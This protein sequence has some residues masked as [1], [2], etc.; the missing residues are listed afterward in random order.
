MLVLLKSKPSSDYNMII[1]RTPFRISFLGGGTDYPVWYENNGGGAVLSVTIDKYCYVICRYLPPFFDFNYRIRY[2]SHE[3][4]KTVDEIRH[5]S[6]RECLRFLEVTQG[7][8]MQHNADL[9]AMSGLGSSSAFTV[10][11]LNALYALR[12]K[13]EVFKRN[14]ALGAIHV[15][16]ERIKE[17][18]GSQDQTAAAYGG[19]NKIEFGGPEKIKVSP[20]VIGGEALKAF[21][22][23]L[24]LF[25]TGFQRNASEIA[26][27]QIRATPRKHAELAAIKAMVDQGQSILVSANGNRLDDFGR[28]LHESWLIKRD[29]TDKISN[30]FIDGAYDAARRA[31]A[32]GGKI[33]GAGGG[34]FLL[35]YVPP[36][37]QEK[38]KEALKNLL[39][40]PFRFENSGSRVIYRMDDV[41]G[42][43]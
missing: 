12:S 32:V 28:L 39:H 2:S 30:S 18:V 22:E 38:V 40:V 19:F 5:P 37:R 26:G 16:Q 43:V 7:I 41:E 29:L 27:D 20:L 31:G 42:R 14:L 21:K 23:R 24:L 3:D 10:G 33:L 4:V 35:L 11:F 36:E 1:T 9:P 6:V 25:F 15:E 17:N 13:E 34:G 8:E